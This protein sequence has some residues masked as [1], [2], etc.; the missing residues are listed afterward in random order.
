MPVPH[1]GHASSDRVRRAGL[2]EVF[3]LWF[4][5][6]A[7]T[8]I[9]VE[10]YDQAALPE[11]QLQVHGRARNQRLEDV[12]P[13]AG[14]LRNQAT[15]RIACAQVGQHI[16]CVLFVQPSAEHGQVLP[17]LES[18]AH[19]SLGDPVH[20]HASATSTASSARTLASITIW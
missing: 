11:D 14:T 18:E 4:L 17:G 16:A 19:S 12:H 13:F 2:I 6:I 8:F 9:L 15:G 10:R 5:F 3:S 7:I 1:E 20:E